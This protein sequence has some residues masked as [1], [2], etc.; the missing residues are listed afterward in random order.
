MMT[1]APR[2]TLRAG[3]A[4]SGAHG[5]LKLLDAFSKAG[6][7]G[8]DAQDLGLQLGQTSC[9]ITGR[10]LAGAGFTNVGAASSAAFDQ[11]LFLELRVRVLDSHQGYAKFFGVGPSAGKAVPR[12]ERPRGDLVSDPACDFAG[13]ELPLRL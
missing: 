5:G 10:L 9:G 1:N 8:R 11:S 13:V 7:F 2:E 4:P 3:L 6:E 12:A